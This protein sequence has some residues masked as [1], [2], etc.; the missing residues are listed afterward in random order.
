MSIKGIV[1]LSFAVTGG[2]FLGLTKLPSNQPRAQ[3]IP[4]CQA[5]PN[6]VSSS[7]VNCHT[8]FHT[9]DNCMSLCRGGFCSCLT[10]HSDEC[11]RPRPR[12]PF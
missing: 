5:A 4:A 3:G 12:P 9:G 1:I 6:W 7:C 8:Q 10:F 11:D 2:F